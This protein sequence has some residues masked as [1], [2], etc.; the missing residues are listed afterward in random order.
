MRAR[1]RAGTRRDSAGPLG[2]IG[3]GVKDIIATA[4]MPT[5]MG[6]PI[7]ADHRPAH[8]AACVA[9]LRAAGAFVFGKTV[10]TPFAFMDPGKTRNPWDPRAHAGRIVVGIG[11]GRRGRATCCA[12]IGTQTNGS[13]IRPAAYCGVVGFKPTLGA[14]PVAGVHP[15]SETFDTVGTFTRTVDDAARLA[16]VLADP[17]RIAPER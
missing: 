7:F 16:S 3:I 10:T 9:R 5:T 17:G 1:R 4:D 14:I 12:A 2:G 6:S 13:V 8:D 11:R 15:F